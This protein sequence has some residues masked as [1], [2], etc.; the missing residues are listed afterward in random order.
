M[1]TTFA[2]S[3]MPNQQRDQ[4]N[5]GQDRDLSQRIEGWQ[6]EDF[7]DP[8]QAERGAGHEA[9]HGTADETCEV[10][11]Q[12]HREVEDQIPR[13]QGLRRGAHDLFDR[14]QDAGID[15]MGIAEPF[16]RP[17]KERWQHDAA[18]DPARHRHGACPTATPATR[19]RCSRRSARARP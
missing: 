17:E 12:A 5:P 13:C 1:N 9:D 19:Q 16:P 6:H 14:W 7:G 15:Q 10:A 4:G 3:P 18:L 11:R 8:R 2:V